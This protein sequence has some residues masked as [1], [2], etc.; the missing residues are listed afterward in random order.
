[1]W[2]Y[3]ELLSKLNNEELAGLRA[4]VVAGTLH[5]KKVK[6]DLAF[7]LTARFYDEKQAAKVQ[8]EFE[9]V[10]AKKGKPTDMQLV[11]ADSKTPLFKIAVEHKLVKSGGEFRRLVTQGGVKLDD[12]KVTD[13]NSTVTAGEHVLQIGKRT[14]AS[15][16]VS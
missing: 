4:E 14:F 12:K 7:E 5:P 9:K 6:Q 2:S 13:A 3:Y 10:F 1:M 15:L 8:A 11:K 16:A